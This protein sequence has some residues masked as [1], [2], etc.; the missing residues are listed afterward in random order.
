MSENMRQ[1]RKEA[2]PAELIA[3]AF[4]L[5]VA[6]GFSAT[7]MD[8]IAA[9]AGVS[10]GTVFL[11]FQSKQALLCAVVEEA[12]LPY[13]RE[14]EVMVE[15]GSGESPEALLRRVLFRFWTVLKDPRVAGLPKLI[16]A[17]A[18]NFPE[19]AA[20]FHEKVVLRLRRM[21]AGI[22]ERGVS[23]GIFLPHDSSLV[24]RLAVAPIM[25]DAMW[26]HSS[27]LHDPYP[28]D[29][30]CFIQG[31]LDVFIRGLLR[32]PERRDGGVQ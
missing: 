11:Y 27:A 1:R 16:N 7:R 19:L 28:G 30:G 13:L 25:F 29:P 9:R 2:R 3:A 5:F 12:I 10:K 4:D 18:G 6:K 22:L 20:Y 17:E 15:E 14:A 24:A 23:A 31:H 26:L 32:Y 8:E 21:L